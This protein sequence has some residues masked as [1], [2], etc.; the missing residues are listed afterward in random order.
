MDK[1]F[2]Y[3]SECKKILSNKEILANLLK[4][5]IPEYKYCSKEEIARKYLE[6]NGPNIVSMNTELKDDTEGEVRF[7]ILFEASA[8]NGNKPIEFIINIECQNKIE[9]LGYPLVSRAIYYCSRLISMQKNTMF[10][11]SDYGDI[12]K[13]YSIWICFT[14]N[15]E[16]ENS[17]HRFALK[18]DSSKKTD[19]FQ[20]N[21]YDKIEIIMLFI[22]Q[23]CSENDKN[24]F[25]MLK[26]ALSASLTKK[27][28][29]TIL[30]EKYGINTFYEGG[31]DA[32][33]TLGEGIYLDGVEDGIQKG[34]KKGI[35][36]GETGKAISNIKSLMQNLNCS[37]DYAFKLLDITDIE[38]QN[39]YK[40]LCQ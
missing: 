39:K 28:R 34:I 32:M 20:K 14:K 36:K 23:N 9:G 29:S 19:F 11:H 33:C 7:D 30:K 18:L 12:K 37:I 31:Y 40:K 8:P 2:E 13:V 27:E 6:G 24:A 38:E 35:E 21:F 15:K 22:N 10:T 5:Y 1:I 17:S 16:L 3:D 26:V 4:E 25:N